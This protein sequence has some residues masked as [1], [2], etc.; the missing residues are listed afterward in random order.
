MI[1]ENVRHIMR[2]FLVGIIGI[3]MI[4]AAARAE[5]A[6]QV[7]VS[8]ISDVNLGTWGMTDAAPSGYFDI[9]AYASSTTPSGSY[10]LIITSS[11]GAFYLANGSQH[12]PYA[13]YW[14]DSGASHLG[15]NSPGTLLS[16]GSKIT[17]RSNAST[18]SSS[19]TLGLAPT[20]RLT[21]KIALSDMQAALAG[22]Y[23]D[24]III[25]L[26]PT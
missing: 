4:C 3:L 21:V 11:N 7:Q 22:T 23:T 6:A 14:E 13:V 17:G 15:T 16:Y 20:A 10:A 1:A 8:N 12:I 18:S 24:Q 5:A 2:Y 25:M 19:C 26:S 9:C